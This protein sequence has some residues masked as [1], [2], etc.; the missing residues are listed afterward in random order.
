MVFFVS[1][2]RIFADYADYAVKRCRVSQVLPDLQEVKG[3]VVMENV[4]GKS[5]LWG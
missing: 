4:G 2:S 3:E 5:Q 1:E